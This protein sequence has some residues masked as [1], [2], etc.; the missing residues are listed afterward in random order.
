M[1]LS[2]GP[3]SRHVF[4]LALPT[5]VQQFLMFFVHHLQLM[6]E[7]LVL[8]TERYV[9]HWFIRRLRTSGRD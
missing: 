2:E 8:D 5:L 4:R 1:P 7:R 3:V 6:Q 9:D